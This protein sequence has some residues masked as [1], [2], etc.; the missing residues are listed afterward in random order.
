MSVFDKIARLWQKEQLNSYKSL[1]AFTESRTAFLVQKSITEY[2]Q[3]RSNMMFS[4]LSS[5]AGFKAAFE[6]ARWHSFP[7]GFSMVSELVL[8]ALRTRLDC[9]AQLAANTM[10]ALVRDVLKHYPQPVGEQQDFWLKAISSIDADLSRSILGEPHPAHD[11]VNPRAREI[12][13][14]LPFHASVRQHD[15][16]MFR[17]TLAF[18]L[19]AIATEL[20]EAVITRN[21]LE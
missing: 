19:A 16:G 15:F 3:A 13:D 8:G 7:A 4:T 12:F 1:A 20:E 11:I 2:A 5:E 17:N 21:V 9:D 10:Q 18:Q 6:R 14:V